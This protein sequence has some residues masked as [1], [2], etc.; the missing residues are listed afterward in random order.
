MIVPRAPQCG[1][2][3]SITDSIV[4]TFHKGSNLTPL[5]VS[6]TTNRIIPSSDRCTQVLNSSTISTLVQ[7]SSLIEQLLFPSDSS[8]D[9][10]MCNRPPA[11]GLDSFIDLTL[12]SSP[13]AQ[14]PYL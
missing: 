10:G 7:F 4:D 8:V 9:A 13:E 2:L 14:P 12:T 11:M 5:H 3:T 1:H 6:R